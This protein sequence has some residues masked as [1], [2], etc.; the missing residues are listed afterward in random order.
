MAKKFSGEPPKT[1]AVI[2]SEL[3]TPTVESFTLMESCRED[4]PVE[5][6]PPMLV[7]LVCK[8][9]GLY[10]TFL[11]RLICGSSP[12]AAAL[13]IGQSYRQICAW[14]ER[15]AGDIEEDED[16][17]CSRFL[18][19]CQRAYAMAIS[20]AEE[21]VFRKDPDR[22]LGKGHAKT[23]YKGQFWTDGTQLQLENPDD[24]LD[25]VAIPDQTEHETQQDKDAADDLGE[26]IKVLEHHQIIQTPQFIDAAKNQYKIG[27]KDD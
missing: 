25:P 22:W 27:Q 4:L 17:Y 11:G 24:P 10:A 20:T 2:A 18:L 3:F 1:A 21:A 6:E 15:G 13:C 12:K 19:D 23:F 14:F 5:P 9:P 26:A 16:T 7:F 8:Q